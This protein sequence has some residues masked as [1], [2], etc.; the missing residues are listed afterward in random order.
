MAYNDYQRNNGINQ[1]IADARANQRQRDAKGRFVPER[2][3][4]KDINDVIKSYEQL[5]KLN[6]RQAQD[7]GAMRRQVDTLMEAQLRQSSPAQAPSKPVSVDDLY[8]DADGVLRRVV[9]ET[10]S[11]E[12]NE[13]KDELKQIRLEKKMVELESKFP[14]WQQKVQDPDFLTWVQDSPYRVRVVQAADQ[15][16]FDAAEEILG[17][18]Y[19][20]STQAN[21]EYEE[22]VATQQL[23]D[24]ML[25]SGGPAPTE[26]VDTYSRVDLMEKRLAAKNG[27][28]VAERWLQAHSD[29]IAQAYAEGRIV[30]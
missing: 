9:K 2:F 22:R 24:A 15:G 27:D 16:D 8:E 25:E 7:L 23:H 19:E 1:E 10:T 17:M 3:K 20:T 29:S 26:L 14:G 18:Y 12:I 28:R 13:L 5:E 30:D 11:N 21:A 6:S 4:G